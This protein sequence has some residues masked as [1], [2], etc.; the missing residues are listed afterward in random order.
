MG[1]LPAPTPSRLSRQAEQWQGPN[2]LAPAMSWNAASALQAV[3]TVSP[4]PRPRCQ[5]RSP[6]GI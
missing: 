6:R 3:G 1:P 5:P 4:H 2:S